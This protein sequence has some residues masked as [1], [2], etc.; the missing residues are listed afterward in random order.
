MLGLYLDYIRLS[1]QYKQ[2]NII[3]FSCLQKLEYSTHQPFSISKRNRKFSFFL[4]DKPVDVLFFL[5]RIVLIIYCINLRSERRERGGRRCNKS[6][7]R[8]NS[9]IVRLQHSRYQTI[10]SNVYK[11]LMPQ[12]AEQLVVVLASTALVI[13]VRERKNVLF[14]QRHNLP[15]A[16]L[17]RQGG[18]VRTLDYT[19]VFTSQLLRV[20]AASLPSLQTFSQTD[21]T[22]GN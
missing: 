8:N 4:Y 11:S 22:E 9:Y 17:T 2:R 7:S 18:L 19:L 3:I 16:W 20:V 15:L 10:H 5:T 6:Q 13:R 1:F 12:L 14:C 21:Q